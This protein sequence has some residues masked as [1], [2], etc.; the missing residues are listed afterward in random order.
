MHQPLDHFSSDNEMLSNM[1]SNM[2]RKP[3]NWEYSGNVI[4]LSFPTHRQAV[5]LAVFG[6]T[7]VLM[8]VAC[9]EG[10]VS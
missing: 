2:S 7:L 9:G 4:P 6:D 10:I 8:K 5:S 1:T 3:S